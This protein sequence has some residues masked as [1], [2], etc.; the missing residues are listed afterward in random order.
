MLIEQEILNTIVA[1]YE[2][3]KAIDGD[4]T[5]QGFLSGLLTAEGII[6]KIIKEHEL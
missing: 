4:D 5:H 3:E 1:R 6:R 2:R